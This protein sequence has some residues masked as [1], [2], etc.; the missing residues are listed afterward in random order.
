M[1]RWVGQV[2]SQAPIYPALKAWLDNH[3]A[4]WGTT[5]EFEQTI[6]ADGAR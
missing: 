6:P 4:D 1:Y 5:F 2:V 3:V